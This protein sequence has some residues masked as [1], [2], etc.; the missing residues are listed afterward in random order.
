MIGGARLVSDRENPWSS[1]GLV[2]A[3]LLVSHKNY[4]LF[5]GRCGRKGKG[6]AKEAK[7]Y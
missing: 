4:S 6:R 5:L 1:P 7:S 3:H 2:V